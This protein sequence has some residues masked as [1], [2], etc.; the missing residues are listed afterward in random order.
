LALRFLRKPLAILCYKNNGQALGGEMQDSRLTRAT[1]AASVIATI[2]WITPTHAE[3][4][5]F[6]GSGTNYSSATDGT[7][8][9]PS[10]GTSGSM[11]T[12]GDFVD[13]T[14][15]GVSLTSVDSISA[16]FNID[17]A[18]DG[19]SETVFVYLNGISIASFTVPDAGGVS[20]LFSVGGSAFFAPIVGNGTYELTMILQDTVAPDGG[21]IDFQDGG[22]VALDGGVR[23]ADVP[24]PATLSLVGVG[25]AAAT[26]L[27]RRKKKVA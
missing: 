10:G 23:V 19:S 21:F 24:E 7:G 2:L 27:R 9:I 6:P 16:G 8:L 18:L 12:A 26:V 13:Q 3:I 22:F 25:L 15:T 20:T 5:P 11:S 4:L 14:F 1:L 17:D